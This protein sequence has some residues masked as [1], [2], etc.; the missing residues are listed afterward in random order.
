VTTPQ[1]LFEGAPIE[2]DDTVAALVEFDGGVTGTIDA[3]LVSRGRRNLL[4]WE[5]N[6]A[7]DAGLEPGAPQ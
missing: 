3:S 7:R 2:P 5:I 4:G 6:C 1:R